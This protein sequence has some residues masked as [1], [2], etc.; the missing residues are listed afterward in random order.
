[1]STG[2]GIESDPIIWLFLKK[3]AAAMIAAIPHVVWAMTLLFSLN[4]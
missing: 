3:V 2:E 1:M 4:I